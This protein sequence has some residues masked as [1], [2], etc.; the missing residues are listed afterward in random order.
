MT[1]DCE[2]DGKKW[3]WIS[4]YLPV[5]KGADQGGLTQAGEVMETAGNLI[6]DGITER[7][8]VIIG[9]GWNAD[10]GAY[11]M[12]DAPGLGTRGEGVRNERGEQLANWAT[13]HGLVITNRKHH[14]AGTIWTNNHQHGR[15]RQL[16]MIMVG[17]VGNVTCSMEDP[18]WQTMGRHKLITA[19]LSFQQGREKSQHKPKQFGQWRRKKPQPGQ[20]HMDVE[21]AS[22]TDLKGCLQYILQQPG[23]TCQQVAKATAKCMEGGFKILRNRRTHGCLMKRAV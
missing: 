7:R 12:E 15:K 11:R 5:D 16:D 20:C 21:T 18:G 2:S 23:T 6:R 22:V 1:L 13:E 3:R 4:V 9:G 14:H 8:F 19:M 10:L 17:R